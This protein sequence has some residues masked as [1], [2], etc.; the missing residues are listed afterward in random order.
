MCLPQYT[1]LH[2]NA[3]GL[4]G[5]YILF[6]QFLVSGCLLSFCYVSYSEGVREGVDWLAQRVKDH[7]ERLGVKT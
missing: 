7:P 4:F 3:I 6:F 5:L 1:Q 2:N